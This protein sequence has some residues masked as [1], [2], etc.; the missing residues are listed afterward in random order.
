MLDFLFFSISFDL[1]LKEDISPECCNDEQASIED[2]SDAEINAQPKSV[3]IFKK[4]M[5][6]LI[7]MPG[8]R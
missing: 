7:K 2:M 4:L 8:I 1:Y 5:T 3:S 6:N